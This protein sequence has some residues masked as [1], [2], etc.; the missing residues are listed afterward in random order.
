MANSN[1][2]RNI[3]AENKKGYVNSG[4]FGFAGLTKAEAEDLRDS[5]FNQG[6]VISFGDGADESEFLFA[7]IFPY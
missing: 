5:Y 2:L 6:E 3:A 4:Y 7:V 1:E